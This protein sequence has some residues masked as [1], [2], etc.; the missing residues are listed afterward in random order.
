MNAIW[1]DR[2]HWLWWPIS[3]T[4]YK[5]S[6]KKLYIEQGL[7]STEYEEV[8]LYRIL[9]CKCSVSILQ[10]VF[11]TGTVTLYTIDATTPEVR[12]KNIKDPLQVKELISDLSIRDR[13]ESG[14]MEFA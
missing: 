3:F 5:L 11:G 6:E 1:R 4:K 8:L 9:D 10:R 7:L 14:L 13:R 2:K 12:L